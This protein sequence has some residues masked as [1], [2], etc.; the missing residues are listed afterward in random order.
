M[1]AQGLLALIY[2]LASDG[3]YHPLEVRVLSPVNHA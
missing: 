1:L 2:D 3:V